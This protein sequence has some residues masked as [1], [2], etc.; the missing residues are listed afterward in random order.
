MTETVEVAVTVPEPGALPEA[1]SAPEPVAVAETVTAAEA[2][3]LESFGDAL[4][5]PALWRNLAVTGAITLAVNAVAEC[6]ALTGGFEHSFDD[7]F[8]LV[9]HS[10][11]SGRHSKLDALWNV[12]VSVFITS[13]VITAQ[14]GLKAR[15]AL[16]GTVQRPSCCC[17]PCLPAQ[18]EG[19]CGRTPPLAPTAAASRLR[20]FR[21]A[22]WLRRPWLRALATALLAAPLLV[23]CFWLLFAGAL[24]MHRFDGRSWAIGKSLAMAIYAVAAFSS[25]WFTEL[26][27]QAQFDAQHLH[28]P[29]LPSL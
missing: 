17:R 7:V 2:S 3:S 15:A 25:S 13:F 1:I 22:A 21:A 8:I 5:V 12:F 10:G 14:G 29:L 19:S 11:A 6:S 9:P 24:G 26:A 28:E 23:V 27:Y 4:R 18:W 20:W 16:R